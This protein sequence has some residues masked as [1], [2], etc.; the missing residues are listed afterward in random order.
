MTDRQRIR[1]WAVRAAALAILVGTPLAAFEIAVE[2]LLRNPTALGFL[3]E[4]I[5]IAVIRIYN[6]RDRLQINMDPR[7]S[8]YDERLLYTLR[9][10][11]CRF[12][13][14]EFDTHYRI[15]SA[16]LRDE[17]DALVAPE[18]I[19]LGD[20]FTMGW[21]VEQDEAFPGRVARMTGL[22]TLNTG[23]T[24]FGTARETLLF[25][26]LDRSNLRAVVL[27]Y[28]ENDYEENRYFATHGTLRPSEKDRFDRLARKAAKNTRYFPFK[29]VY[30]VFRVSIRATGGPPITP[31]QEVDV[32]L[33]LLRRITEAAGEAPVLVFDYR[34][35][36]DRHR[37]FNDA[38]ARRLAGDPT[39]GPRVRVV[40]VAAD[41]DG[42]D[43]FI[44]DDHWRAQGH[45][46]VAAGL[47]RH[48]ASPRSIGNA[49]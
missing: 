36:R 17:E 42:D 4:P 16:G 22:K 24:S 35:S 10:G 33:P 26:R 32:L 31:D 6:H 7:C 12:A 41:L 43:L 28:S 46:K 38:L 30:S 14:R 5:R 9:P 37:R 49:R 18:V 15:N 21:G 29:Y 34:P 13:N 2:T 3:P 47:A 45:E 39:L 11:Q 44:L 19:F 40:D 20:S 25:E 8:R 48:I 23:I 1:G 27:Q